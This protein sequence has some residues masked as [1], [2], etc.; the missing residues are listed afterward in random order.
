MNY[1]C[2]AEQVDP[3]YTGCLFTTA[4]ELAALWLRLFSVDLDVAAKDE[5]GYGTELRQLA[6][7]VVKSRQQWHE[8]WLEVVPSVVAKSTGHKL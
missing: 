6:D 8:A 4:A 7:N 3:G 5:R 1:V 2:A